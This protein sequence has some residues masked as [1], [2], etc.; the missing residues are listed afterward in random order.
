MSPWSD[1]P[2]VPG[3]LMR[4]TWPLYDQPLVPQHFGPSA[5]PE[6]CASA[7]EPWRI[8]MQKCQQAWEERRRPGLARR[9]RFLRE[10]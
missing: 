8:A 10:N 9:D 2:G 7:T 1:L 3:A 6:Q 4:D 5:T